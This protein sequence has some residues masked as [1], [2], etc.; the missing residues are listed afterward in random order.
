MK[1]AKVEIAI[2]EQTAA[3]LAA[4]L[5]GHLECFA[6]GDHPELERLADTLAGR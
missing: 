4:L 6:P 1:K 2:D 3:A 5:A